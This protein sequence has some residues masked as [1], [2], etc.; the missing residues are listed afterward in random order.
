MILTT[1]DPVNSLVGQ[2]SY[3]DGAS[4]QSH[5]F[6]VVRANDGLSPDE[7]DR[8]RY[9]TLLIGTYA[10]ARADG[11]VLFTVHDTAA[12]YDQPIAITAS[13]SLGASPYQAP[14]GFSQWG[15]F[16]VPRRLNWTLNATYYD[17]V[18]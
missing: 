6:I 8:T 14:S 4:P 12:L 16:I 3:V 7:G 5:P 18:S 2:Y 17:F 13:K 11:A 9:G 1:S 10:F 15:L